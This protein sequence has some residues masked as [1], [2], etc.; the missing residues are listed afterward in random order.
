MASEHSLLDRLGGKMATAVFVLTLL[1]FVVETELTQYV[2]TTLGY[3][4]PYFL[5]Y[6]VHSSFWII[7]PL[8]LIYLTYTTNYSTGALLKGVIRSLSDHLSSGSDG[9][10]FP[11]RRFSVLVFILTLGITVP[12]LLWFI[13]VS[14]A[15]ISD[16]TAIW[17]TNAF[18]AYALSL[19]FFNLTWQWRPLSAVVV[20]TIGVTAVVYGGVASPTY[21]SASVRN[22]Q[23]S[24]P[25]IGNLLTLVAS[26]AYGL[27]Q[28][29]YKKY[30][31]LP[32]SPTSP[33][34]D[35]YERVPD[36]E[37]PTEQP[38]A[39][40]SAF[41]YPPPFG[42]HP[43]FITSA[44]GLCTLITLWTP[45][46]ILHHS[47]I[48]PFRLPENLQTYLAIS[49]I[50]LSGVMFNACFMILL[51]IWGPIITSVGNLLTIVLVFVT[52][53]F[54]GPG[55]ELL[56]FWSVI[57]SLMIVVAFSI[58]TYDMSIRAS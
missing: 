18:F 17:N 11:L 24:A 29:L 38:S 34:H 48:E 35:S 36:S 40:A 51:G 2:Q 47:G 33:S 55:L 28:V 30:I 4:Q 56:T 26:I 50:A 43:N 54:F 8:H 20:A 13:A 7:L 46:P 6:I 53:I 3:R 14:L 31:A 25:L 41:A 16:V 52:D 15:S 27:Y 37:A 49:G 44:V 58:L 21:D 9:I 57:G 1:A 5:F 39:T 22:D 19:Y 23:L 12:A 32:T 45:L 10:S 42:L